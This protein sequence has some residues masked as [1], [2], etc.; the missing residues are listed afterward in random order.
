MQALVQSI[1]LQ[2]PPEHGD[3][4]EFGDWWRAPMSFLKN[5]CW[6]DKFVAT[7]VPSDA[8]ISFQNKQRMVEKLVSIVAKR[9][10]V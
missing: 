4:L 3:V 2:F 1:T 8:S 6:L 5:I 9:L 7:V 10:R